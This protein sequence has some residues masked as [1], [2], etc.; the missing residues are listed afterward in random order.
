MDFDNIN[1]AYQE[2]NENVLSEWLK[3]HPEIREEFTT[4]TG[5]PLERVSI[6]KDHNYLEN[7]NFPGQFPFTRGI[8]PTMYRSEYWVMGQYSGFA[9]AKEANKRLKYLIDQGQT[10][11]SIALDLPT[12]MG[13]DSDNDKSVGEVGRVGVAMDSL[14][15]IEELLEGIPFEKVKQIRTTANAI[16]PIALAM[17][18]AFA[19]K[20]NI[21]PNSIR[22]LI[23]NDILKEFLGRGTYIYPPKQSV[24]LSIDVIEYTSKHLPNWVPMAICG[25]HIRDSGSTA[26]QELAYTFANAIAYI[27]EALNRGLDIDDFASKLFTFLAADMDIFEE[28][29]KFRAARRIWAKLMKERFNS[30]KDECMA[31][32]IFAYTL[33]GSLTSQQPLNN[34]VRVTLQALTAVM[35]G[36]QVLATSSYD[37]ALGLPSEKAVTTALRTQQII[38]YESGVTGMVDPLGGSHAL[39]S[40]TDQL[41]QEVETELNK[42]ESLGGAITSIENGIIQKRISDSAYEYQ[43]RMETGDRSVVGVNKFCHSE[44]GSEMPVFKVSPVAEKEQRERV[45]NLK[46]NRE[47]DKVR[48][49]LDQIKIAAEKEENLIPSII[50]SIKNYATVE[51]I[52]NVLREVYGTYKDPA[53]F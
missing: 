40:L 37:E 46:N 23:Q 48:K 50:D 22:V 13:I 43:K 7:I 27:E 30:E 1:K 47:N 31:L 41:E 21:D 33:G 2:W 8:N 4:K 29:A 14:Q 34:I 15:D 3:K 10:G 5:L 11:F 19:E 42:I 35:G 16:S 44:E 49:C 52:S 45:K 36:V 20:N 12:Q 38:A 25:Y 53:V 17:I 24:K 51:E 6:P 28:A 32:N 39:E 26:V 18:V 9:S